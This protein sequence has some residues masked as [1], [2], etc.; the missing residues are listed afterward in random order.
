MIFESAGE[1]AEVHDARRSGETQ[2]V[3]CDQALVAVGALHELV[4]KAGA[5][6]RSVR[7]GLRE[8]LQMQA[9]GVL[10]SNFDGEGVVEAEGRAEGQ[11]ETLLVFRLH[12]IV[13][14]FPICCGRLLQD[15]GQRCA[16]VFEIDV[17]ASGEQALVRDVSAAEI[18]TSLD[19]K[20]SFVFDLLGDEFSEDDLL[21]EVLASDDDAGS[22]RTG[23]EKGG[24]EEKCDG[25]RREGTAFSRAAGQFRTFYGTTESRALPLQQIAASPSPPARVIS[26]Y[27]ARC[28]ES[29]FS[30]QPSSVSAAKAIN[31]AGMAPARI[32]ALFTMVS[33][34]KMSS[35]SPPA[36]IAAAMV[37]RPMDITM[38]TRTPAR[39]TLAASGNSTW[40]RS[41]QSVRPMPRA[42]STMALSTPVIPA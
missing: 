24:R 33:P 38:A 9:T 14:R 35:P 29:R 10:A 2:A 25:E 28:G 41:C 1:Q 22:V 42:A 6:L 23:G 16:G 21:G 40:N 3:G 5:P 36:P 34:R 37:A 17:D 11:V 39:I 12:A 19:R 31:A 13:N 18:E 32:T 20:M 15:C 30:S 27:A 26:H 4:P 7:G 8:C